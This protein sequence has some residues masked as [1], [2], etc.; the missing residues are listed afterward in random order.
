M[1]KSLIAL[2]VAG[3]SFNAA[4]VDLS[5]ANQAAIDAS[6]QNYASE[7]IVSPTATLKAVAINNAVALN[8]KVNATP[9]EIAGAAAKSFY[10]RIDVAGA[11][12]SGVTLGQVIGGWTVVNVQDNSIVAKTTADAAFVAAAGP[13]PAHFV[14]PA[15]LTFTADAVVADKAGATVKV[16]VFNDQ[17]NAVSGQAGFDVVANAKSGKL[18]GFTQGFKVG[19]TVP[20]NPAKIAVEKDALEFNTGTSAQLFTVNSDVAA[21]GTTVLDITGSAITN[22]TLLGKW[23]VKGPFLVGS[24]VNGGAALTAE[25]AAK[26]VTVTANN[27]VIYALPA[28]NN[29]PITEGVFTATYTP[30]ATQANIYALTKQDFTFDLTKNGSSDDQDLVFSADSSYK[31]FV[32]VSNLGGQAGKISFTVYGD[33]GSSATF[34]LSAVAG[35]ETATLNAQASTSQIALKDLHAAAVAAG[36]AEKAGKLRIVASG[37]VSKLSLQT[38]VLSTD[39]TTFS[40]F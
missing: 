31:T 9:A 11:K 19:I 24:T 1:K 15:A 6:A 29:T 20:V 33:D 30:D 36:L 35:Q 21:A 25:T 17:N 28:K 5:A 23:E 16:R 10:A 32:R 37:D 12:I 26:A 7:I 22:A 40:R 8:E 2:A 14:M 34:P 4:A 3:L 18:F 38:Y 13:V 27:A 39:G